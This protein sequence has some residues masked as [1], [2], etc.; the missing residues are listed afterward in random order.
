MK[1]NLSI[2]KVYQFENLIFIQIRSPISHPSL[3]AE[4]LVQ[5]VNEEKIKDL[6]LLSSAN[7]SWCMDKY[8]QE[9]QYDLVLKKD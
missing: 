2:K 5:W 7:A 8:L 3:F 4:E 1:V 9:G 6:V